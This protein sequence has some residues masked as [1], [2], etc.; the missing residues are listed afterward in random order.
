[1][2]T[3]NIDYG[4]A[5]I[6]AFNE[7]AAAGEIAFDPQAVHE[8]VRLYGQMII[9][10]QKVRQ[11]LTLAKD[12]KG[13]GGF[14]SGQQLQAGFVNKA[15]DGIEVINQLIDGAMRL[16]EAYLRAGRLISEA[17][18]VSADRLKIMGDAAGVGGG[19]Q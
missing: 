15:A 14:T 1:M 17:D 8:A 3:T 16:Q 11:K 2:S 6:K 5:Q 10:L 9:G 7:A 19:I 18:Q 13:F 12:A 4:Q